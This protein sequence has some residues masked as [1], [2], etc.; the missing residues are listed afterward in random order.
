[1]NVRRLGPTLLHEFPSVEATVRVWSMRIW[2]LA[3]DKVFE[4]RVTLVDPK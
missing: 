4:Q 1:M 3:N 2:A